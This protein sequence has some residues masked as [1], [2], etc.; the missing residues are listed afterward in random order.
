MGNARVSIGW[1]G[2]TRA[3]FGSDDSGSWI[4]CAEPA[5]PPL[6]SIVYRSANYRLGGASLYVS[7]MCLGGR[8]ITLA[9]DAQ[10]ASFSSM[11]QNAI[12]AGC[13]DFIGSPQQIA[14]EL[15]KMSLHPY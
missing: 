8:G 7:N 12:A 9:Q 2:E 13:V 1:I 3:F 10:S 6:S 4:F 14:S 15:T 5:P 11:P